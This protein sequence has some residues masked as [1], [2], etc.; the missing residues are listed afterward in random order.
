MILLVECNKVTLFDMTLP[1]NT[2]IK[3]KI[4]K[5]TLLCSGVSITSPIF[6]TTCSQKNYKAELAVK[7][8]NS[9]LKK[10]TKERMDTKLAILS[11]LNTSN[12]RMRV[13]PRVKVTL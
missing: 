12:R 13:Q 10:V 5:K 4:K 9:M 7:I 8:V 2:K 3:L 1:N 6:H 11:Q